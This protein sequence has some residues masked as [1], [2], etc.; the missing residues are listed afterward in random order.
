MKEQPAMNSRQKELL[1]TLLF[2]PGPVLLQ[3]LANSVKVS[4]R[5]VQREMD[6]LESI[7][8]QYGLDLIKKAGS[9]LQISG[10]DQD[11]YRLQESL[12]APEE[13]PV[14]T[15]EERQ[16]GLI[17]DLLLSREPVKL[18]VFSRKYGVTEATISHDMDRIEGWFKN[19]GVQLIRKPG[20]GIYLEGTEQQLRMAASNVLKQ[21]ITVEEWLELFSLSNSEDG[22][23]FPPNHLKELVRNRLLEFVQVPDIL[24]VEKAV[25]E[26]IHP[27]ADIQL[28]DREYVNLVV[29]L[30]LAV[31]RV[32]HGELIEDKTFDP[33]P[34]TETKEYVMAQRISE[35][36][37]QYLNISIPAVEV[38]YIALHLQGV[39]WNPYSSTQLN[40]D[41]DG[42]FWMDLAQSL[43]RAAEHHLGE[44]LSEDEALLEGLI[45]H[46]VPAVNRIQ[47][48]LQI[49]NPMLDQIKEN[50][51]E[52]FAACR[53]AAAYLSRKTG[54][55]I[56]EAE[57]GYL[58][59]HVGA[60]LLRKK[61]ATNRNYSA[62]VVCASGIGTSQFLVSRLKKELPNI[63][64][65]AVVSVS[66][67]KD[68]LES[69]H[70]IDLIIST[71]TLPSMPSERV[72]IVTPFINN[73][74]LAMIRNVME[75]ISSPHA[76]E[77]QDNRPSSVMLSVARYGEAMVQILR[78]LEIAEEVRPGSE[79]LLT[80][81]ET[82]K[83]SA[84]VSDVESLIRDLE[85]RER[86]GS[87]ILDELAMVHAKTTG[88]KELLTAVF[89]LQAPVPW[90]G[91]DGQSQPVRTF[92]LLAAPLTAP[93][94]HLEMISDIS[95]AL[96]EEP[97]VDAL[98]TAPAEELRN[99]LEEILSAGYFDKTERIL[100]DQ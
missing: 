92:L 86:L 5:T 38:G 76:Q 54:H 47:L 48:G 65:K 91:A 32:R 99:I 100:K 83:K 64:I 27:K 96:V 33:L 1:R 80:L 50:Y 25:R 61:D 44:R 45:T 73:K 72:V 74:D 68:W 46:L 66:G 15:P 93:K 77:S 81:V 8:R 59:M 85:Q 26:V 53:E 78:N 87:F 3:E 55:R 30:T 19:F 69:H 24:S 70:P 52:V 63:E 2:A 22:I 4:I 9:G 56:P 89:R 51:S 42:L 14:Y 75:R 7:L 17:R 49:H 94:E 82:V 97:F 39:R 34:V 62:I 58:S 21:G 41:P 98:G 29:H 71:V 60:A 31:E 23:S 16:Q 6:A 84:A 79:L 67:I 20:L 88:V 36:L 12:S 40:N 18:Y 43:V 35:L 28:T 10:T 57:V 90:K 37:E 13:A 95:A 11:K